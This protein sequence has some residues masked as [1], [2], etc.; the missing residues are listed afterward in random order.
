MARS[1]NWV[2]LGSCNPRFEP[3]LSF[4]FPP[5]E[6]DR[7]NQLLFLRL[8]LVSSRKSRAGRSC[9]N[10]P[11]VY[12]SVMDTQLYEAHLQ[13]ERKQVTFDLKEN[14]QGTFL[15]ITEE[16]CGRRNSIII[17][18]TGLEQFRDSLNEVIK[19]NQ[20]PVESRTILPL[21]RQNAETPNLTVRRI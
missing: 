21:G 15:R 19:F 4:L 2:R 11:K 8:G 18:M 7:Q 16:V 9:Q 12:V 14:L 1:R 5:P 20:T 17:P 6:P 3:R 13:I 10:R